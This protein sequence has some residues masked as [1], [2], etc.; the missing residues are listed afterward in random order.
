MN[1]M[2]DMNE[3]LWRWQSLCDK[4]PLFMSFMFIRVIHVIA[5]V[6][7]ISLAKY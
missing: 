6:S 7:T 1:D 2:N 3:E 4:R 5:I